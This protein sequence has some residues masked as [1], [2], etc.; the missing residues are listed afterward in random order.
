MSTFRD[1]YVDNHF[2]DNFISLRLNIFIALF[3]RI[4]LSTFILKGAFISELA[5]LEQ[6]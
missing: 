3:T 1:S 4:K 2:R 6:N 5:I